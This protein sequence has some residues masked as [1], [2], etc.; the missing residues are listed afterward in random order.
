M[1]MGKWNAKT[2]DR[3]LRSHLPGSQLCTVFC[4]YLPNFLRAPQVQQDGGLHQE[5]NFRGLLAPIA[6]AG[7]IHMN[8]RT[9]PP[10]DSVTNTPPQWVLCGFNK[11]LYTPGVFCFTESFPQSLSYHSFNPFPS[12]LMHNV[13]APH[14]TLILQTIKQIKER[15]LVY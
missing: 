2:I 13:R 15:V 6:I 1:L 11:D 5:M 3:S 7:S 14:H 12:Q 10:L 8:Y 4:Q 9:S